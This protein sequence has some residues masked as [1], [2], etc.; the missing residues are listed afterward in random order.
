MPQQ[1]LNGS[2]PIKIYN[3][4]IPKDHKS[5]D[6]KGDSMPIKASGGLYHK[7]PTPSTINP[8]FYSILN[9]VVPISAIRIE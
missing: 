9:A 4:I 2:L 3:I 1:P 7:L 8:C 5:K 6:L